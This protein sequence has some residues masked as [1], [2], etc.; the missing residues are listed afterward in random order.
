MEH[1]DVV[2]LINTLN[3][4]NTNLKDISDSLRD[5]SRTKTKKTDKELMRQRADGDLDLI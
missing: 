5:V 4:I 1:S 3:N 2:R